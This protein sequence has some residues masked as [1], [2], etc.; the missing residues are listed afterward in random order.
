M[1]PWRLVRRF[2]ATSL[3]A[4]AGVNAAP[5]EPT[6]GNWS[7]D[8]FELSSTVQNLGSDGRRA[9]N[10]TVSF[11]YDGGATKTIALTAGMT[12]YEMGNAFEDAIESAA[13]IAVSQCHKVLSP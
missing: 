4:G 10:G 5:G 9:S 13:S 8:T 1:R 7:G 3:N 2:P 6:A 11:S 12:P